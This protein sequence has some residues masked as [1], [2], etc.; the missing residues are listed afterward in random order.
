MTV[1]EVMDE[2][3]EASSLS[4]FLFGM[5]E[6][7]DEH[8]KEALEAASDMLDRYISILEDMKVQKP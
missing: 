8:A 5:T 7:P 2:I 1:K 3:K 6:K 4:K